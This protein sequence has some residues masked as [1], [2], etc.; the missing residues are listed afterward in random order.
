[1][2]KRS[3][4]LAGE[5]QCPHVLRH[6]QRLTRS[7]VHE[8]QCISYIHVYA[9]PV[10]PGREPPLAFITAQDSGFEGIACVD[11]VAR[12]A[13]LALRVHEETGSAGA[14]RLARDWLRFVIY[15][16]EP[17]GRFTNF[18]LDEAGTKNQSGRTSYAGGRW[19]TAR[20]LWALA[21]AWRVTGDEGYLRHIRRGRLT[22]TRDMKVKGIQALALMELYQCR[23]DEALRRRICALCDAIVASG[24][25]YFRDRVGQAEV[26]LWGYHQLQAVARAAHLFSRL[27]YAAACA[28]TVHSLVEPVIDNGFY[29]TYPS[30]REPQCAYCV[31]TLV[32]G[33]EELYRLTHAPSYRDLALACA[34]WLD[35]NNPAGL[36]LYDAGTGRCADG[37]TA[38]RPSPH[39]GAESAIEAGFMELVRR[40]VQGRERVPEVSI[41]SQLAR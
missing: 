17:D 4:P 5:E 6:L 41:S 25:A 37:V 27:D 28:S 40:H 18:I 9:C 3:L 14:L 1:M 30:R 24:P 32:A 13:I 7:F 10:G 39:C 21:T 20:A 2:M 29:D 34:A 38:G 36:A 12:A 35:G 26:A 31:S 15:M 11:D 22:P 33:L 19:W 23:P 16:Q 8:G